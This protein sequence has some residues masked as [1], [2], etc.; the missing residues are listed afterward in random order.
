M[1]PVVLLNTARSSNADM[2][3]H[4]QTPP[5]QRGETILLIRGEADAMILKLTA[6]PVSVAGRGVV[7]LSPL[8]GAMPGAALTWAGEQFHAYRPTLSDF[9]QQ[10]RRRAQIIT[11]KDAG[12]L[13]LLTGV[14]PGGRVAEAGSGSGAMTLMLAHAV[15]PTGRV[16]SF[17][18][19]EEFLR[20]ARENVEGAGLAD[21]V[22]FQ[23]RDVQATGWGLTDLDAIILDLPEP[24]EVL[25]PAREALAPGGHVGV[26][27][28]TYNQLERTVRTARSLG[29]RQIRSVELLERA[30]HVGEGGTRPEFDMLGH[31]GFL[32]VARRLE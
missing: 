8:I 27:T 10:L 32:T 11:P 18:R 23:L 21:R 26:Y 1:S 6:S 7:D 14:G 28:P 3:E 22:E 15:G 12:Q 30:L 16:Y 20:V 2:G 13:I 29:F 17:D 25:A 4:E 9:F 24:W 19:R 5:F 31:T